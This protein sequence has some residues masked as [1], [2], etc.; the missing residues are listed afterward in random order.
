MANDL[1]GWRIH[2]MRR[3]IPSARQRQIPAGNQQYGAGADRLDY[4][5]IELIVLGGLYDRETQ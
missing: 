2:Y 4:K 3:G 5:H 1:H